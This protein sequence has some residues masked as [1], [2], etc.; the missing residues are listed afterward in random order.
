[1]PIIS[2]PIAVTASAMHTQGVNK[3]ILR[4]FAAKTYPEGVI[5]PNN[6]RSGFLFYEL[7]EGQKD[8]AGLSLEVTVRDVASEEMITLTAP[9]PAAT[10][11]E[12]AKDVPLDDDDGFDD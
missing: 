4:D 2:I 9:L 12:I 11:K 5:P 3:K 8:L 7:K 1:M 10:F 6:E